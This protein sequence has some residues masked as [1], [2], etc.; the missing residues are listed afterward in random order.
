VI[1]SSRVKSRTSNGVQYRNLVL[2]DDAI[3]LRL[4]SKPRR[5]HGVNISNDVG[6]V[7]GVGEGW[8]GERGS[9]APYFG[10]HLD[11]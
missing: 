4:F 9:R 5:L 8:R 11:P 6:G 10:V 7:K 2:S 3:Y 1:S